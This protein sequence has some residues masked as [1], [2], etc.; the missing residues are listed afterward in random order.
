MASIPVLDSTVRK[1]VEEAVSDLVRVSAWGDYAYVSLPIFMP[2]GAPATVRIRLSQ[3]GFHVD[4]GGYAYREL[5]SAGAERSFPKAAA[6]AAKAEELETDR[7]RIFVE[8]GETELMRAICDVALAS[9]NVVADVYSRLVDD[10]IAVIED[11]LQARLTSIFGTAIVESGEGITGA[12][13]K[14]WD[15]SAAVHLSSGLVIFQAV[16]NN[17]NSVN[18]ASTAF[19]DFR[20]LPNPPVRVAVVKDKAE[21]GLGLNI[22]SQAGRVIQGDQSDETYVRAAS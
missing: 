10:D 18:K 17:A 1:A 16:S 2:S 22:L 8:T 19:H 14:K 5:E 3:G 7:R 12:S 15:M 13:S 20:E 6:S 11:Y 9:R 21:M 4:D